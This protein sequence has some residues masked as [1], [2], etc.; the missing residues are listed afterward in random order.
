MRFSE[1]GASASPR[2]PFR[3]QSHS[4]T[5]ELTEQ[6]QGALSHRRYAGTG[7]RWRDAEDNTLQDFGVDEEAEDDDIPLAE[8]LERK[9]N[10]RKA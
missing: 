4:I 6:A 3:A 5:D 2:M 9:K 10:I 7:P 8:V 1:K